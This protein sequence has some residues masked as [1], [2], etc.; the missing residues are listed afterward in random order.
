[1]FLLSKTKAEPASGNHAS[2]IDDGG[3]TSFSPFEETSSTRSRAGT[4]SSLNNNNNNN[5]NNNSSHHYS[6]S[7][8]DDSDNS[9]GISDTR[10]VPPSSTSTTSATFAHTNNPPSTRQHPRVASTSGILPRLFQHLY[11]PKKMILGV[12]A[13]IFSIIIWE[14]FFVSPQDRLIP[15]DFSDTFLDWVESNPLWGLGAILIVIAGAVVSMVPI[16]TPLA[17]GCG[18]IY[19]GVYGWKLGLF[20]STIVSM[21]GSTLGAVCCFLL[22]RYLM[23]DTVKRWVRN[24]PVF[25]AIDVGE[26]K[27][28]SR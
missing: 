4:D 9:S 27:E 13:S 18:Y 20:V 26:W 24:Y 7:I 3:A 14:S 11:H 8:V 1:M 10:A 25:D 21:A 23:R 15:P 22:G 17:L 19:R 28:T 6:H 2:I 5:D 16:G 12:I